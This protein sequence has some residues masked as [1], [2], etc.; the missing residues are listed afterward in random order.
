M[1]KNS[2]KGH[3][4]EDR[5]DSDEHNVRKQKTMKKIEKNDGGSTF[6]SGGD[7]PASANTDT[8]VGCDAGILCKI[9]SDATYRN[10]GRKLGTGEVDNEVECTVDGEE[11]A[12]VQ[13]HNDR[14]CVEH[15]DLNKAVT[16]RD[17]NT[18][19]RNHV[20]ASRHGSRQ[21]V[22]SRIGKANCKAVSL[23][24]RQNRRRVLKNEAVKAPFLWRR[25]IRRSVR[26]L[27]PARENTV[28]LLREDSIQFL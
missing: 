23:V 26:R 3:G 2:K 6:G 12:S 28:G 21:P 5:L 19:G 1:L 17:C 8:E 13:D 22:L 16:Q 4:E 27:P 20:P 11:N 10:S 25:P 9:D 24:P 15:N 14:G 7:P 18:K